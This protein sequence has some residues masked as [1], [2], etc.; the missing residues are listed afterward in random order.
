M[1]YNEFNSIF[2]LT[3]GSLTFGSIAMCVQYSLRSKCENVVCKCL[4]FSLNIHRNVEVE[5]EIELGMNRP[6]ELGEEKV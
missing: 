4:G 2:F 5:E 1:W 3:V 6:V